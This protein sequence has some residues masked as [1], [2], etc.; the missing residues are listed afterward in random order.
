MQVLHLFSTLFKSFSSCPW[1]II[2]TAAPNVPKY[3]QS[4]FGLN[5]DSTFHRHGYKDTHNTSN[6]HAINRILHIH[7]NI[8]KFSNM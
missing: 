8:C 2:V 6:V 5:H 3:T 1:L 7:I 4:D